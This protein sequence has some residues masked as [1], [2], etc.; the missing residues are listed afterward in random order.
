MNIVLKEFM[1]YIQLQ[2]Y[3]FHSTDYKIGSLLFLIEILG[4]LLVP[5]PHRQPI[6]QDEPGLGAHPIALSLHMVAFNETLFVHLEY[7]ATRNSVTVGGYT[8][9]DSFSYA[10]KGG[11]SGIDGVLD[12][13]SRTNGCQVQIVFLWQS[14][15]SEDP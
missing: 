5:E 14:L 12:I 15:R 2:G 6:R 11:Y 1:S 9:V 13:G 7:C 10:N 4:C 8:K 3:G